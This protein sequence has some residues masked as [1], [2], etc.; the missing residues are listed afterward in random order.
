MPPNTTRQI[1]H[2][3]TRFP[4]PR[5]TLVHQKWPSSI[6]IPP[7]YNL[8][9]DSTTAV[10]SGSKTLAHM[11]EEFLNCCS[12]SVLEIACFRS[13]A[14]R[15]LFAMVGTEGYLPTLSKY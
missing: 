10:V 7:D 4:E 14:L 2:E 6:C 8:V 13:G 11:I 1:T 5:S 9:P 15:G 3:G 12:P